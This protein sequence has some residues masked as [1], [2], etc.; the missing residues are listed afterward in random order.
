MK[1]MLVGAFFTLSTVFLSQAQNAFTI[2]AANPNVNG[3]AI[4]GESGAKMIRL[5]LIR[6]GKY[7]VYDEFDMA[8]VVKAN[9]E[10][11]A[12]CFGQTCLV[13]LGE[14][15]KTD[16]VICGSIDGLSNKIAITLKIINVKNKSIEKSAIKEFAN[17]PNE[18]QRM[19]EIVLKEMH[20]VEVDKVL[21]DRLAFKNDIITS[22]NVGKVNNSG[23]RIGIAG[24]IG[25][26]YEFATR[27]QEN[28]GLEILPA[29]SMIGYQLEGQ[30][31]GTENFSALVE[32]IVNVSGL[33]QG[34]FIPTFT[35]MNGFRFGKGNWEFAFGP[36]FGL[37][38]TKEGFFDEYNKFGGGA[39]K[40]YST[41]EVQSGSINGL[42]VNTQTI[43]TQYGYKLEKHAHTKGIT[44]INTSFVFAFGRTFQAG[45]LNIPINLFYSSQRGGG[46]AGVNVG[47]NVVKSK[48][49]LNP[50]Q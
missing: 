41:E 46:F 47:F 25:K 3:V 10:F 20:G 4:S 48:K 18:V 35:L 33:E 19:I 29:V 7:K 34:Q 5:E 32:G 17:Q 38:R 31:V 2:A 11:Q 1:K 30:Y 23:P 49:S 39:D 13:K 26:V 44:S 36:G 45:A 16:F 43:S 42:A 8:D 12:N 37:K 15:L 24:T 9:P 21:Q 27:K 6:L 50:G 28:G 14:A 40:F 22:N